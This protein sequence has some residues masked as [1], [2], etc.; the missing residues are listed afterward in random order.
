MIK[1]EAAE[2]NRRKKSISE[3]MFKKANKNKE[4]ESSDSVNPADLTDSEAAIVATFLENEQGG[5]SFKDLANDVYGNPIE[6]PN[7]K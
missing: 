4:N 6:K 5:K 2:K 3:R 1:K 7:L